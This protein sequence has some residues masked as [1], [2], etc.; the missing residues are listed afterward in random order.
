MRQA[1]AIIV[2]ILIAAAPM[3]AQEVVIDPTNLVETILIAERTAREY[4]TL[5]EQYQTIVRMARGLGSLDRYRIPTIGI[6]S[7]DLSRWP[8]AAPWLQG[9]NSGDPYGGLYEQT[10]RVLERPGVL[11]NALPPA[12]R[13]A[14][15]AR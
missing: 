14:I 8:F 9:L 11:L 12:A 4:E 5:I 7:H 13:K 1:I 6:T 10:A 15:K 3:R 2:L